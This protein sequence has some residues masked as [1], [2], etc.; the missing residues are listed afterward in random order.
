MT[1]Q[2]TYT[3]FFSYFAHSPIFSAR[4][5]VSARPTC[6]PKRSPS[7]GPHHLQREWWF[8]SS[9]GSPASKS[10]RSCEWSRCHSGQTSM[11]MHE[12]VH[13]YRTEAV[14]V[15][16]ESVCSTNPL[17][18]ISHRPDTLPKRFLRT[19]GNTA[20]GHSSSTQKSFSHAIL[21][22]DCIPMIGAKSSSCAMVGPGH[23][24]SIRVYNDRIILTPRISK[25]LGGAWPPHVVGFRHVG[26]TSSGAAPDRFA[27]PRNPLKSSN[28]MSV[29]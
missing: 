29:T 6:R 2:T 15:E 22:G 28:I 20:H 16:E 24:F 26:D 13:C 18:C 3:C 21:T 23:K 19:H 14:M 7:T 9:I 12:G 1:P 25:Q 5:H 4:P 10:R 11:F 8:P 27:T 17:H